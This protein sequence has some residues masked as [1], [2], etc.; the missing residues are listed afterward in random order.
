MPLLV[1]TEVKQFVATD[2]FPPRLV[3][4]KRLTPRP[5]FGMKSAAVSTLL[6]ACAKNAKI[7]LSAVDKTPVIR[8]IPP[9][10]QHY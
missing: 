4:V 9:L 3:V 1:Q 5:S 6:A 7:V 10:W 8:I 2:V